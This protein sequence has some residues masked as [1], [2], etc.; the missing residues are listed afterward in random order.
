MLKLIATIITGCL[1]MTAQAHATSDAPMLHL[2]TEKGTV[3]I[4]LYPE[5]APNHVERVKTL[6]E[7]GFYD[8]VVFHRVLDGF[9]AQTGD[10][11]GTGMGGSDKPDLKAEFNDVTHKRGVVSMARAADPNSANS[12]FFIV[13]ADS[14]FLDGKYTA[15]GRVVEGMQYVDAL[16]K[17]NEARNGQVQDPDKIVE[18][19]VVNEDDVAKQE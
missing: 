15:F 7:E 10:P 6:T 14:T 3:V 12:Q 4:E 1:L 16:K 19:S 13:L 18:M 8:G 5:K 11:T 17:G 2:Q 9:M